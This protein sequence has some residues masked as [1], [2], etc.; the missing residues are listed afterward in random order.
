MKVSISKLSFT[1]N[2]MAPS[3]TVNWP[4]RVNIGSSKGL[5]ST[6]NKP[7]AK[8]MMSQ[9]PM[10]SDTSSAR[11]FTWQQHKTHIGLIPWL[12]RSWIYHE[13]N[14]YPRQHK[15]SFWQ[16]GSYMWQLSVSRW[17]LVLYF[18]DTEFHTFFSGQVPI[19]SDIHVVRTF[20]DMSG[21]RP[22]CRSWP[23]CSL[24]PFP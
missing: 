13:I 1:E 4:Q 21:A 18:P 12:L 20:P 11:K 3:K 16:P 23:D 15:K 19:S 5:V 24:R 6:N 8:P 10:S 7:L 2:D 9:S 17:R 22:S 14:F